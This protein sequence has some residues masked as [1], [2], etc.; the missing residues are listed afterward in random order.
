MKVGSDPTGRNRGRLDEVHPGQALRED[1]PV[2]P[3]VTGIALSVDAGDHVSDRVPTVEAHGTPGAFRV[4]AVD[5]DALGEP[6][7][8]IVAVT[9]DVARVVRPGLCRQVRADQR[10]ATVGAD[11][12]IERPRRPVG[13]PRRRAVAVRAER[14]EGQVV[15]VPVVGDPGPQRP[16]QDAPVVRDNRCRLP[17]LHPSERCAVGDDP[18]PAD[19]LE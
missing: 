6:R 17:P 3:A 16:P 12:H 14:G 5:G 9:D 8:G 2:H 1:Q 15:V 4:G 11:E 10:A 7:L 19:Q 13:E 18:Q